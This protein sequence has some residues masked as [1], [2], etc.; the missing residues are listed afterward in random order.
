MSDE[1]EFELGLENLVKEFLIEIR[2]M[3]WAFDDEDD[4][5]WRHEQSEEVS[6]SAL[7]GEFE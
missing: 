7:T 5:P 4:D 2:L 3:A 6:N 1:I